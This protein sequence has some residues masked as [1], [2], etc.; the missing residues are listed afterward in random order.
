MAVKSGLRLQSNFDT[1]T[2]VRNYS[3]TQHTG[4]TS[5]RRE[6]WITAYDNAAHLQADFRLLQCRPKE[7]EEK[8]SFSPVV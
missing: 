1:P 4:H 7:S 5:V 2:V 8:L 6:L 3:S